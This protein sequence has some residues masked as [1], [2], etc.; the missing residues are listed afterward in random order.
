MQVMYYIPFIILVAL[1]LI[2]LMIV[3]TFTTFPALLIRAC[4]T[5]TQMGSL[6]LPIEYVG[7]EDGCSKAEENVSAWL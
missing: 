2:F 7:P 5:F 4:I 6:G 3:H 1:S